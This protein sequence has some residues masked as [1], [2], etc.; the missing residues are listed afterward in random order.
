MGGINRTCHWQQSAAAAA[1]LPHLG[2]DFGRCIAVHLTIQQQHEL[3]NI[4][5]HVHS[6]FTNV[7]AAPNS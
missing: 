4:I 6:S 5:L 2:E 7:T 3:A 1:R